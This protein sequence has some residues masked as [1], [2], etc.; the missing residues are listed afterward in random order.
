MGVFLNL[1]KRKKVKITFPT[2]KSAKRK[3]GG[4]NI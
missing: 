3:K 1:W 2:H 4:K